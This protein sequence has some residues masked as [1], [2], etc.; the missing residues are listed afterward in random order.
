MARAAIESTDNIIRTLAILVLAMLPVVRAA[1]DC[2]ASEL[3]GSE[4]MNTVFDRLMP[5]IDAWWSAA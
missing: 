1:D 4:R 2:C 5:A 3:D